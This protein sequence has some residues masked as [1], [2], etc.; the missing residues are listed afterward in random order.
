MYPQEQELVEKLRAEKS[1]QTPGGML[2]TKA[3]DEPCRASLR[4]RVMRD[5]A[6]ARHESH[7][8]YQLTELADLLE[9][10]PDVARILDLVE[11]VRG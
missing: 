6:R 5:L 7:K 10:H 9:K 2:H 11:S 4:E 3:T 1:A 8:T